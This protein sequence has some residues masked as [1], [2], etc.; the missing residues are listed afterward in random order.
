M[1]QPDRALTDQEL[2]AVKDDPRADLSLLSREERDRMG[3]LTTGAE[4]APATEA[5][6]GPAQAPAPEDPTTI[7]DR[8]VNALPMLGGAAG[9][10]AGGI[11]GTAFG[12]GIGGMPG[13]IG[14][15]T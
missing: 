6:I 10:I 8:L 12:M 7:L 13:A 14:G 5:Q 9:G 4:T 2:L 15:A 11:G 3:R 1:A